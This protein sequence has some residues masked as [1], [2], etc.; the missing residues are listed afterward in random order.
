[1]ELFCPSLRSPQMDQ[2]A[3]DLGRRVNTLVQNRFGGD[4]QRA[5][6][7]YAQGRPEVS[8][9]QVS[10]LLSDADVG[11]FVTRGAHTSGVMDRF[12]TNRSGGISWQE[13]QA[14]MR[15]VGQGR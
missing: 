13:F 14:G 4:S 12:D 8:R 15:S 1:R 5:F 7:H 2:R 11:S 9:E 6:N 3:I 10:K